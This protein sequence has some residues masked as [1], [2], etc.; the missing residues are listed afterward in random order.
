MNQV[1]FC[2][3]AQIHSRGEEVQSCS[4]RRWLSTN[5]DRNYSLP[6]KQLDFYW[7]WIKRELLYCIHSLGSVYMVL[8]KKMHLDCSKHIYN[9]ITQNS[10]YKHYDLNIMKLISNPSLSTCHVSSPPFLI[11]WGD[12]RRKR[13]KSSL[14]N[15]M[16]N[17]NIN[18]EI[19]ELH[20]I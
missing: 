13:E 14:H 16:W 8:E 9:F 1:G 3:D 7:L 12:R 4:K 5:L 19:I 18:K 15:K 11:W 2:N 6:I 10:N 17:K 20:K